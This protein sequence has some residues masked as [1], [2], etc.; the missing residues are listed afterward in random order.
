MSTHTAA[1]RQAR[2]TIRNSIPTIIESTKNNSPSS[3]PFSRQILLTFRAPTV[4]LLLTVASFFFF[5]ARCVP[6]MP[7]VDTRYFK[8]ELCRRGMQINAFIMLDILLSAEIYIYIWWINVY[9]FR[10]CPEMPFGDV[11]LHLQVLIYIECCNVGQTNDR[12]RGS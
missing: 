7:R 1:H 3:L 12:F 11:M 9:V 2:Y 8:S 5:A 6:L 4:W 10:L